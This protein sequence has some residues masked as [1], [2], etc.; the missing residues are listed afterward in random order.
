MI[1]LIIVIALAGLVVWGITTLIPMPAPFQ[2]AIY[3]IA[4]VCLVIYVLSFFGLVGDDWTHYHE[5]H[6]GRP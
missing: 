1:E 2:K 5:H 6:W 4:V 3:V